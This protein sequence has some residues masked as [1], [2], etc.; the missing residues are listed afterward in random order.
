MLSLGLVQPYERNQ[1]RRRTDSN[2]VLRFLCV[3]SHFKGEV[4]E[5]AYT[6]I[7]TFVVLVMIWFG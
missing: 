6:E 5:I 7:F 2:K 3:V 1:S 4:I